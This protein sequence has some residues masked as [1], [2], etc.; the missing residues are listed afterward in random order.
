[1]NVS[2]V[3]FRLAL[4]IVCETIEHG[5]S[6]VVIQVSTYDDRMDHVALI[7]RAAQQLPFHV[8]LS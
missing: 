8:L 7:K 6:N 4:V 2:K 1:M 5:P 3:L